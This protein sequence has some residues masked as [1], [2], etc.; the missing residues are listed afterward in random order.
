MYIEED[1]ASKLLGISR[2]QLRFILE[3]HR[4]EYKFTVKNEVYYL[5]SSSFNKLKK[6][7][8][9][10]TENIKSLIKEFYD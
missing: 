7:I 1:R 5:N 4:D 6:D 9:R 2:M 10:S 8:S 3:A